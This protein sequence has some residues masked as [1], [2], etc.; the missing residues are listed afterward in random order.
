[1]TAPPDRS[2]V[3]PFAAFTGHR[4]PNLLEPARE[5][6]TGVAFPVWYRLPPYRLALTLNPSH[7]AA[8][9]DP[10][11]AS[12]L[13]MRILDA[14]VDFGKLERSLDA[15]RKRYPLYPVVLEL[16]AGVGDALSVAARAGRLPVRG[17]VLRGETSDVSL[18]RQLTNADHIPADVVEWLSFRGHRLSPVLAELIRKIFAEAPGHHEL[19]SLCREIGAVESS[20]R[21]RFHKKSLAPPSRWLQVARALHAVL[22]LQAEPERP[23]LPLALELGY[24]DHSA[25]S[26][27]L[28]RAFGVRPGAVRG[29]LGWEW[30]M[31]RWMARRGRAERRSGRLASAGGMGTR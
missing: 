23:L 31:E 30:L 9:T 12:V 20:A 11:A 13:G 6:A 22:R 1:M 7:I 14:R 5:G 17:V 24:A 16:E 28:Y 10:G 26:H 21:F 8:G 25:L 29:L 4:F 18:R 3:P 2:S 19:T 27:Q 15:L